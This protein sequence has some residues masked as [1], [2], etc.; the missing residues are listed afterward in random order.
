MGYK[1]YPALLAP[2]TRHFSFFAFFDSL[3]VGCAAAVIL[4]HHRDLIRQRL[5]HQ[6]RKALALGL[7]L[8]LVPYALTK[9]RW[10]RPLTVPFGNSSQAFGFAILLL[11]SVQYPQWGAFRA[12]NWGRVCRIGVLSYS[13]YIWQGLFCTSP[14]VFGLDPVWW[15]SFPGWLVPV[16]IVSFTSYYGFERP[17][18][19]LRARL[20]RA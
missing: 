9:L 8:V 10:L 5:E 12:L 4:A 16:F 17:F 7:V 20:R 15:M 11:L 1:S 14:K 2:L 13:I 6:P 19:K 3:A 18:L